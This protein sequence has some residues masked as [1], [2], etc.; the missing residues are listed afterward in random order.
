MTFKTTATVAAAL[1]FGLAVAYLFAGG[2][3]AARWQIEA[4]E[5]ILLYGRRIGAY[6][7]GLAL[8]LYLAR[9]IPNSVARRAISTGAMV[10][11]SLLAALGIWEFSAG[12]AA[13]PILLSAGL[14]LLVAVAFARHLLIDRR[15]AS[16]EPGNSTALPEGS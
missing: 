2:L 1:T 13:A 3:L 14:E 7:L 12:R 10:A 15:T 8:L 11:T 6:F 16:A 5:G 9:S 4:T